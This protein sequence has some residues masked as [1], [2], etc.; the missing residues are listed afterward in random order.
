MKKIILYFLA[1][2]GLLFIVFTILKIYNFYKLEKITQSYWDNC[3]KVEVGMT[4]SE[5][6]EIIGDL[7]YQYWTQDE[8]SGEII[9]SE[10]N[11]KIKYSL[12]YPMILAG[13]DNMRLRFDPNTLIITEVFC[14]E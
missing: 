11:G 4:L 3:K 14:G 9:I 1:F 10:Y 7:K 6:R 8:Y 12:E 5:A 13:S 2:I